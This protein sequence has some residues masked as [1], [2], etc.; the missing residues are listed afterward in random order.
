MKKI[1]NIKSG[2]VAAFIALG[3]VYG[4]TP[5]EAKDANPLTQANL[6]ASFTAVTDDGNH[7]TITSSNDENIAYH[8]YKIITTDGTEPAIDD[9]VV[10]R[11]SNTYMITFPTPGT[12]TVQHRVVGRTGGTN[13]MT[14]Q[15][16]VVTTLA[17]GPN[18]IASPN[19]ENPS[20]WTVLNIAA[21]GL[22]TFNEGSATLTGGVGENA[23]KAIYQAIEV[24]EGDYRMDMTV[25]GPGSVDTWFEVYVS[26]VAP[27]PNA[28]YS[29]GGKKIQLNT[30]GG[31]GN[32]PFNGQLATISCGDAPGPIVT[33]EEAGTV[34]FLIK[35]GSTGGNGAINSITVSNVEFR[36]LE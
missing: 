36:M 12:Y 13:S 21:N 30:W 31:C 28:D 18:L 22:W 29:A 20:D 16:F 11:D 8:T 25:S 35:G 24:E 34:Y 15:T 19:F 5:D 26:P 2:F 27:T 4:C 33:F 3:L 23:H 32:T 14:E 17:L 10:V 7:Y 9:E 1:I 6:D